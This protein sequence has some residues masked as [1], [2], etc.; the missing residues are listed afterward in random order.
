MLIKTF[1]SAVYG[2]EATTIT[3]EVNWMTTAKD[4]TIVGLPDSAVKESL[5][6]VESTI[7]TNGFVM[8]RTKVVVNLA[9]ANIKKT[10]SAFD[11]PIAIG[12]LSATEQLRNRESLD[13]YV[14]MG[15][16]S[17]NGEVRSIKGALPIALQAR[18]EGFKGLI[19]PKANAKEAVKK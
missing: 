11:L 19:I 12:F 3:I 18:K 16:L 15:E 5:Q 13:K 9:P 17:L 10:G 1:G 6:R 14:I 4:P 8:P 7:K 2:V